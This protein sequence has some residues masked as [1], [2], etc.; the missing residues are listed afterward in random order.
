[1]NAVSIAVFLTTVAVLCPSCRLS[2]PGDASGVSTAEQLRQANR[3]LA[4]YRNRYGALPSATA[5]KRARHDLRQL[6]RT[7]PGKSLKE[8][9]GIM[10]KPD[11]VYV[12]GDRECWDYLNA[13][14]APVTGKVVPKLG[15][16]F[17]KG[18]V[19]RLDAAF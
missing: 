12:S 16:W 18:R 15:V 9:A 7:L 10:G 1:M 17:S 8:V 11:N 2:G 3:Q 4:E 5:P 14:V 6:Q 19:D 13:C